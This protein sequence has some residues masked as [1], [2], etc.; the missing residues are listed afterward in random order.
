MELW[1]VFGG[2]SEYLNAPR[3]LAH[4]CRHILIGKQRAEAEQRA[5][6]QAELDALNRR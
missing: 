4:R 1:K 2:R 5:K 6:E 3:R